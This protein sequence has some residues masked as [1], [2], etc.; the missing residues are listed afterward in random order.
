MPS[1]SGLR[2]GAAHTTIGS[3]NQFIIPNDPWYHF[4]VSLAVAPGLP[5]AVTGCFDLGFG[6]GAVGPGRAFDALA[7]FQFLVDQEEVLD[8]QPLATLATVGAS[9]SPSMITADSRERAAATA[10]SAHK[11]RDRGAHHCRSASVQFS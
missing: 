3:D 5:Q 10:V 6:G 1:L 9:A 7:R 11:P 4:R 8:L 2:V